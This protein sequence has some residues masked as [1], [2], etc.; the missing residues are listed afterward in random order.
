MKVSCKLWNRLRQLDRL[1]LILLLTPLF[2]YFYTY[3]FQLPKH[4]T[5]SFIFFVFFFCIYLFI[6]YWGKFKWPDFALFSLF[7]AIYEAT[8]HFILS[9][10]NSLHERV[11]ITEFYHYIK[12]VTIT[13]L[14]VVIYN[15]RFSKMF[16][17]ISIKI[18]KV[19]VLVTAVISILQVINPAFLLPTED[20]NSIYQNIYTFRRSSVYGFDTP[21]SLG[22][23]YIPLLAVLIGYMSFTHQRYRYIFLILGGISAFVSNIRFVMIGFLL[24][25]FLII[26]SGKNRLQGIIK[27][28]F[29][30]IFGVFAFSYLF[31]IIGY[32]ITDWYN[33]RLMAEGDLEHTTRYYAVLN[34]IKFFPE[35][36]F[37]GTGYLTDDIR[38]ASNLVGSSH[39]HVGYLSHLV[40]YGVFGCFFLFGFWFL[41]LKRMYRTAKGTGFYGSMIGFITFLFAFATMSQ[42]VIFYAGIIFCMVFDK[43]FYDLSLKRNYILRKS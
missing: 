37:L 39:I 20:E 41:L 34:F 23:S 13:F 36:P 12:Y 35:T 16:I 5:F 10:Q 11:F 30:I 24:I 32:D 25:T 17:T 14:I 6:R 26:L 29:F 40:Y 7:F 33:N 2:S 1:A 8:W 18:M 31:N 9:Y 27:Y 43:Y 3:I 15:T 4:F 38:E 19:L 28:V 22:L 42:S 21:G